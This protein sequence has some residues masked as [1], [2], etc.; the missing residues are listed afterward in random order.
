MD[1]FLKEG[2]IEIWGETV[3][4]CMEFTNVMPDT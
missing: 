3:L 4:H 1:V 2:T